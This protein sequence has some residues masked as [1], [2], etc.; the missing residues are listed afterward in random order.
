[1]EPLLLSSSRAFPS[2]PKENPIPMTSHPHS[3]STS[4][5]PPLICFLSLW[6]CLDI[7]YKWDHIICD[8]CV[9]SFVKETQLGVFQVHPRCGAYQNFIP[10]F[11]FFF[12]RYC[13][14]REIL[15][16]RPGIE[17]RPAL[18]AWNPNQLPGN[19]P[20]HFFLWLSNIS[21]YG[22][23]VLFIHSSTDGHLGYFRL[24][25]IVT[26][27]AMNIAYKGWCENLFSIL[28]VNA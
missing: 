20:L 25:A 10:F 11:F 26:N 28:L 2:P 18:R 23:A 16:P 3:H 21:L 27:G 6:I 15:V 1:M 24:L 17:S 9:C 7:L 8:L 14:V 5:R 12:C 19:S 13:K 4:P 22:W